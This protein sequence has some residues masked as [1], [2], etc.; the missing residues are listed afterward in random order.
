MIGAVQRG[1]YSE[2]STAWGAPGIR[3]QA[4]GTRYQTP[5]IRHQARG[6]SSHGLGKT[7]CTPE[8]G[9]LCTP[10]PHVT[11]WWT[12]PESNMPGN[13]GGFDES[14]DIEKVGG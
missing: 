4:S 6:P 9:L 8:T 5:G 11:K 3:H 2:P 10:T 13:N 1:C 14:R 12:E 7:R